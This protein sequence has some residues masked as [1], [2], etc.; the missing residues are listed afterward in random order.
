MRLWTPA[1][2]VKLCSAVLRR[3][4]S[5]NLLKGLSVGTVRKC[6]VVEGNQKSGGAR[7]PLWSPE[8]RQDHGARS[9]PAAG[10]AGLP[11]E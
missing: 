8:D 5:E 2:Q 7:P 11:L 6:A 10:R 4:V 1:D 9:S 3:I